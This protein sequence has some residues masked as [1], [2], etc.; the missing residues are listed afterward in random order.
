MTTSA[1][2]GDCPHKSRCAGC[3]LIDLPYAEQL[4]QK[5]SRVTTAHARFDALGTLA[6][7]PTRPADPVVGY[8]TR[9]KLVVAAGPR[10]GLY[11]KNEDHV[12]VDIPSC[13]ALSPVLA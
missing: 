11:A 10:I 6:I 2:P 3:P 8:R 5:R 13:R 12:V 4:D 7:G 9:A 1:T